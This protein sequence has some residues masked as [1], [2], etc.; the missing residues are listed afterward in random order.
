MVMRSVVSF[1]FAVWSLASFVPITSATAQEQSEQLSPVLEATSLKEALQRLA[2]TL[3]EEASAAEAAE[4]LL[5]RDLETRV[6][7]MPFV[8]SKRW[9]LSAKTL[10]PDVK[11]HTFSSTQ[12]AALTRQ[13][14]IT[15]VREKTTTFRTYADYLRDLSSNIEPER[16]PETLDQLQSA[17]VLPD[18]EM[19]LLQPADPDFRRRLEVSGGL[20]PILE[21]LDGTNGLAPFVVGFGSA[22]V[23]F[24]AVGALVYDR[25]GEG[26]IPICTGTLIAP[27]IVLTA[28]HCFCD[29]RAKGG[30]F[31]RDAVSCRDATYFRNTTRSGALDP[32]GH[33]FFLQHVGRVALSGIVVIP[34]QFNWPLADLAVL[35]LEKQ[36][37]SV[38]PAE[39][40][41][42]QV[43][44]PSSA[45]LIVGF[46]LHSKLDN[47]GE[48]LS[49]G[50]EPKSQGLKIFGYTDIG[51]CD[52][53]G[54][55]EENFICWRYTEA[56][57]DRVLASTCHGDSGGPLFSSRNGEWVLA[58]V[59]SG[60]G[61]CVPGSSAFDVE[62]ATY[63]PWIAATIKEIEPPAERESSVNPLRALANEGRFAA[64]NRYRRFSQ[65]SEEWNRVFSIPEA[66]HLLRVAVNATPGADSLELTLVTADEER[67][68]ALGGDDALYSC[69]V[70]E[71]PAGEWRLSVRG[72]TPREFQVVATVF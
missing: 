5:T 14:A 47:E 68:C 71:P 41:R 60:G 29:L 36:I 56:V 50:V 30:Q 24:P 6:E 12:A 4:D 15:S 37:T 33:A 62:V 16:G 69:E 38:E 23:D 53:V 55:P 35:T 13:N 1:T 45:G 27:H 31:N 26:F 72:S 54:R 70:E 43:V 58:G 39:V 48:S 9:G 49:T 46:G 42:D 28:A 22:T 59:T 3:E 19:M 44:Q 52:D 8:A 10:A 66:T 7:D 61:D 17:F 57:A 18:V 32:A 40:S 21:V 63:E 65:M 51:S 64:A 25:A 34:D 67:R 11:A 20:P 2:D